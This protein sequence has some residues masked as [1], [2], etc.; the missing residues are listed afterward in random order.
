MLSSRERLNQRQGK[1]GTPRHEYLQQLITEYQYTSQIL[2]KEEIVANLA[3]FGYDPINYASFCH[4]HVMDLFID[5]LD[6]AQNPDEDIQRGIQMHTNDPRK[7]VHRNVPLNTSAS[8]KYSLQEFAL[9]G[10]CNC[11]P[12]PILQ[13]D[14]LSND[15]IPL[16]LYYIN[17]QYPQRP[18]PNAETSL[19]LMISALTICYFLLDSPAFACL[20]EES[21][22]SR[23]HHLCEQHENPQVVNI[24]SAFLSRY[25]EIIQTA[26]D[27]RNIE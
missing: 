13:Q 1:Y 3:N 20:T 7:P 22:V 23:M 11:I 27:T 12:D 14:F 8:M 9:G 16:I 2:R 21:V 17:D 15:A 24:A 26:E 10:I 25:G 18:L 6:E 4:L 5:I 19:N